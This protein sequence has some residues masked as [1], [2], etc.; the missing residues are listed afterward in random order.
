MAEVLVGVTVAAAAVAVGGYFVKRRNRRIQ[1]TKVFGKPLSDIKVKKLDPNTG[2]PTP[3]EQVVRTIEARGMN[4]PGLFN[5]QGHEERIKEI[6]TNIN[7]DK[8]TLKSYLTN[9]PINVIGGL[10]IYYF[11]ELPVSVFP[12]QIFHEIIE[13]ERSNYDQQEW[14]RNARQVLG[15]IPIRNHC[16]I[17]RLMGLLSNIRSETDQEAQARKLSEIFS[18]N[19]FFSDNH[20]LAEILF[21][22]SPQIQ[23]FVIKVI[24]NERSLFEQGQE[25][26]GTL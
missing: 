12:S 21:Q 5:F 11:R 2:I 8:A 14:I 25:S 9:E 22:S 7:K 26:A 17:Q 18:P 20:Q 24:L 10:L 4:E 3:I 6:A 23:S 13:L 15:R 19:L 16:L 1:D